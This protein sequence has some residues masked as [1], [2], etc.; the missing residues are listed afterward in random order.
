MLGAYFT[1]THTDTSSKYSLKTSLWFTADFVVLVPYL[2]TKVVAHPQ[3][4]SAACFLTT[5]TKSSC[6]T[7]LSKTH[8]RHIPLHTN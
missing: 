6:S 8:M 4:Q 2:W 1:N 5:T 7:L 3:G